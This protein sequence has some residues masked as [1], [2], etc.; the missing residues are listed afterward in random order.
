LVTENLLLEKL[1]E[2]LRSHNHCNRKCLK[3]TWYKNSLIVCQQVRTPIFFTLT[4][5]CA[6]LL[7]SATTGKEDFKLFITL[8]ISHVMFFLLAFAVT[9]QFSVK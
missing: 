2:P 5:T 3:I 9:A 7:S 6:F 4:C 1:T 8:I